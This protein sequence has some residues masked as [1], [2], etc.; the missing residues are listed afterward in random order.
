MVFPTSRKKI[1]T[2][3]GWSII[4]LGW[5]SKNPR[6]SNQAVNKGKKEKKK[7]KD[8]KPWAEAV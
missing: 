1:D 5:D 6:A 8:K 3:N 7:K 2:Q 4:I